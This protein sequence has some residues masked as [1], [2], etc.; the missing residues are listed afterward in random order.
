M[1]L[2]GNTREWALYCWYFFS[3]ILIVL[4]RNA[5]VDYYIRMLIKLVSIG[6]FAYIGV[7]I[8]VIT[9][10]NFMMVKN[11]LVKSKSKEAAA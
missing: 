4:M 9:M 1:R 10:D 8:N 6:L 3:S 5:H 11:V 7:R 2:N